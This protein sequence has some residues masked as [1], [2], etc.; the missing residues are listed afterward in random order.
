MD[1]HEYT[2]N[3]QNGNGSQLNVSQVDYSQIPLRALNVSCRRLLSK[4]LL[5]ELPLPTRSGIT[6]DWQG[7]CELAQMPYKMVMF[8]KTCSDPVNEMINFWCTYQPCPSVEDLFD[9]LKLMERFDVMD[10]IQPFIDRDSNAYLN[11]VESDTWK[12]S[13][14]K[15]LQVISTNNFSEEISNTIPYT[16]HDVQVQATEGSCTVAKYDAYISYVDDDEDFVA[17]M[18]DALEGTFKLRLFIRNR[19]LLPGV[20]I[21]EA[22]LHLINE[23]CEKIILVISQSSLT[24]PHCEWQAVIA[25]ANAINKSIHAR[26]VIPIVCKPC[27]IPIRYRHLARLDFTKKDTF[28]NLWQKLYSSIKSRTPEVYLGY[29]GTST[30]SFQVFSDEG[31][32][33]LMPNTTITS[34]ASTRRISSISSPLNVNSE[35]INKTS[36]K[37]IATCRSNRSRSPTPE[38][39]ITESIPSQ[40]SLTTSATPT[41]ETTKRKHKRK[42]SKLFSRQSSS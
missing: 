21:S 5:P 17:S 40:T 4:G 41:L 37:S 18:S 29:T 19:D 31:S 3:D 15:P 24:D 33:V 39:E 12:L 2:L 38:T 25:Q 27:S 26:K 13:S 36:P 32:P 16:E 6:R 1:N 14:S 30:C 9:N 34:V 7:L 11:S 42:F 8:Y 23:R 22:D 10:D 28:G 20:V 35:N